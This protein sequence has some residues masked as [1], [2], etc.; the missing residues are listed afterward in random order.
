MFIF[1]QFDKTIDLE[2]IIINEPKPKYEIKK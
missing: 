1:S 2:V